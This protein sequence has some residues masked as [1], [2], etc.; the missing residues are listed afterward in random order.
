MSFILKNL[1]IAKAH[2]TIMSSP[3]LIVPLWADYEVTSSS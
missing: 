1:L 3:G 2:S